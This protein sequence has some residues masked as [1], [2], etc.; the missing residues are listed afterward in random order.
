MFEKYIQTVNPNE[1][2]FQAF[3]SK[4]ITEK[5]VKSPDSVPYSELY[6]IIKEGIREYL[7]QE[8]LRS[9]K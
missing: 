3:I 7:R 1:E 4:Y 2:R 9:K 8:E 5:G 6:K